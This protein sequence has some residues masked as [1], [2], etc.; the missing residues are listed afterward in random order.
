MA[1]ELVS[2]PIK[3]G[4]SFQFVMSPF[5][6]SEPARPCATTATS[7]WTRFTNEIWIWTAHRG[8]TVVPPWSYQSCHFW[9]GSGVFST[10]FW[11]RFE[12]VCKWSPKKLH[13]PLGW[14][15]WLW[16]NSIR[17]HAI[18]YSY[19]TSWELYLIIWNDYIVI[20][21]ILYIMVFPMSYCLMM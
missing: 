4:G 5:T 20:Y 18:K 10:C 2:F 19:P 14:H 15:V 3:N 12:K 1:M 9:G 6:G 11:G 7:S 17:I 13:W 16:Y 8:D 21:H